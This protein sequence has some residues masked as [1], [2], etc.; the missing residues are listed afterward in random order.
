MRNWVKSN[1]TISENIDSKSYKKSR[2]SN[3]SVQSVKKKKD[4]KKE[5]EDK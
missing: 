1:S 5:E 4:F 2:M 3:T